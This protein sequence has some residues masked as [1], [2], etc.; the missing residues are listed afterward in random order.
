MV[1][2]LQERTWVQSINMQEKY[3]LA[4]NNIPELLIEKNVE[5]NENTS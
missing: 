4:K 1:E 3:R 2:C 5:A